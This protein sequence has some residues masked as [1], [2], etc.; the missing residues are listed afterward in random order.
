MSNGGDKN[1]QDY[2][3]SAVKQ[4]LIRRD[5]SVAAGYEFVKTKS[6]KG[7]DIMVPKS[8][9]VGME[10]DHYLQTYTPS[11]VIP[12][13]TS[14]DQTGVQSSAVHIAQFRIPEKKDIHW[15]ELYIV[16]DYTYGAD[17]SNDYIGVIPGPLWFDR[18]DICLDSNSAPVQSVYM[19]VDW[20]MAIVLMTQEEVY[21][22]A[23]AS[24]GWL[25]PANA[26]G[27]TIVFAGAAA[28]VVTYVPS[29]YRCPLS[30]YPVQPMTTATTTTGFT[31]NRN[32]KVFNMV[33][34]LKTCFINQIGFFSL[35]WLDGGFMTINAYVDASPV[36]YKSHT[37]NVPAISNP[38]TNFLLVARCVSLNPQKDAK[39]DAL[40]DIT[41]KRGGIHLTINDV[42]R[43]TFTLPTA[44]ANSGTA[45]ITLD[46]FVGKRLAF[47]LAIARPTKSSTLGAK[48]KLGTNATNPVPLL[49]GTAT[50]INGLLT[51]LGYPSTTS[52]LPTVDFMN[53]N[54]DFLYSNGLNTGMK[55]SFH[56]NLLLNN[57]GF[58][59]NPW[60]LG[61]IHGQNSYAPL[62]Y[63][64]L[65]FVFC[66][67]L[68]NWLDGGWYTGSLEIQQG[69]K[70]R[71]QYSD[72]GTD[73]AVAVYD[74]YGGQVRTLHL[75]RN[76]GGIKFEDD[77]YSTSV[78]KAL[79][80]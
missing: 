20:R 23:L 44:P 41:E 69:S 77:P 25:N 21:A 47:L 46:D 75:D 64:D 27:S 34:P 33:I 38:T 35:E 60:K 78:N 62:N 37:D 24:G 18:F 4:P 61:L 50:T 22:Y 66:S 19:D 26:P 55:A 14:F 45:Y 74:L 9:I 40:K 8:Q 51:H 52:N 73:T 17:A 53:A 54:G 29:T 65:I 63:S 59:T 16:F 76:G 49:G 80:K 15:T 70:I 48:W 12:S 2:K 31:D 36:Y 72:S 10:K 3:L 57:Q 58:R 30:I 39:V 6:T 43:R 28:N 13:A 11:V 32:G 56:Q 79:I 7:E 71:L 5:V 67:S 1:L 68:V 42:M